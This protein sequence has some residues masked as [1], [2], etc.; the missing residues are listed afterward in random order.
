MI[1]QIS[2]DFDLEKT[3]ESGQCFRWEKAD[4]TTREDA[5][6]SP[7]DSADPVSAQ[8]K[9][10][11]DGTGTDLTSVGSRAG[12]T[13]AD[14]T[15]GEGKDDV[16]NVG[17]TAGGS[18]ADSANRPC[19][20]R[21][22]AGSSCLYITALDPGQG[23]YDLDC[24]EEEFAGFWHGYFDLNENYRRIRERIDP[25]KDPFLRQAADR[26]KGIRI[27][28][29][30]PWEMLITFIISQNKN[31]P[32]IRR[33]VESL[34]KSCGQKKTDSRGIPY[35]AF[36]TP[37]QVASL[38][39]EALAECRLGYRCKY[40]N[41]AAEAVLSEKINLEAL[42][43]ADEKTAIASL[44]GLYGVGVKVANCVSL[45]GLHHVDA[46]PVD[47]WVKR[48]LAEE[49]PD[50]YPFEQ[51][52]P[53]NGIYQQYMFAYYRHQASQITGAKPVKKQKAEMNRGRKKLE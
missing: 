34:A 33:C 27:L 30:D 47:V 14:V 28:R 5:P 2:D 9:G 49:Y 24:T 22:I 13:N 23:L 3:A 53:F 18:K 16:T 48:I 43:A 21:I 32:G 10:R 42:R 20:Y 41:A 17:L 46:F 40:V 12:G 38:S 1:T 31:I 7:S 37:Q 11:D 4:T 51:Y 39:G 36:P 29:Q 26:E 50:G 35:Y 52:S 45:F 25:E 19:T 8:C 6:C 44:T 15:A